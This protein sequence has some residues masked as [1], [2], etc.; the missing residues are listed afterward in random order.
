VPPHRIL[1]TTAF[2]LAASYVTVFAMAVAA[3][4]AVTYFVTVGALELQ[5]DGR[6][7]R[8]TGA[9][10]SVYDT[11]GLPGLLSAVRK[12]ETSHPNGA[13]DY[14][15]VVDA[16]KR[17][18]RL[19]KWPSARG[20]SDLAYPEQ[21]GDIGKRRYLVSDLGRGLTLVVAADPEQIDEVEQA[22]LDG[23]LSAFGAVLLL[24]SIGAIALSLALL[25][26]VEVIRRTAD[27]IIAGDLGRRI[28]LRGTGDD[29]DRLSWTLNSMLD[30]IGELMES[31]REVSAHIAHDLKT[32][33][34]RLRQRLEAAQARAS[35]DAQVEVEAAM[36]QAD[37]IL[38][39]FSALLRIAQIESGTRRAGFAALDL[40]EILAT[41]VEAFAPAAEDTGHPLTTDIAPGVC[42]V[43]DR[44]LLTQTFANLVE[45]AI[46]HTPTG[47]RIAVAL[48]QKDGRAIATVSD[49]GPG[50]P[51]AERE[52]IFHRFHRLEESRAVTGSGL[53]L[54]LVKAVAEIHA[55]TL[56]AEDAGPGLRITLEFPP[57]VE[58]GPA[59]GV[60]LTKTEKAGR[61]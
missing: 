55:V 25:K 50:V 34:A 3:L 5:L 21:D 12:H 44:E 18:G 43:G 26:R 42:V 36:A 22:I 24:G 59:S 19:T 52:R 23:F 20:W 30:R 2:R 10:S 38:A 41:V 48:G 61:S 39:T 31:L 46:R 56:A 32:P 16:T 29:F 15:V 1:H 27:A 53:G 47:T 54:S 35:G 17:A 33:L 7:S 9:L 14:A 4:G 6:I 13:L 11:R 8:E 40:S 57:G 60:T 49:D 37:D 45:N 58:P 28:P 51:T